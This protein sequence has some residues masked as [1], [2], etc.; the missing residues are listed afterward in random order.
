LGAYNAS[1]YNPS[2]Y[3]A[4]VVG[5]S[6]ADNGATYTGA[7]GWFNLSVARTVGW[8][9]A[10]IVLGAPNGANTTVSM[11]LDGTDVLDETLGTTLGVNTIAVDGGW[12]T[13]LGAFDN[14]AVTVPEPGTVS[15]LFCGSLVCLALRRCK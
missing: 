4:R 11:F 10:A 3:Q 1:A 7:N 14:F 5:A 9:T 8:H 6:T 15:L 2:V 12:G 13:T